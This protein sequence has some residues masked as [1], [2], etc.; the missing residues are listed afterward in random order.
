MTAQCLMNNSRKRAPADEAFCA[1][2]RA[3]DRVS[4]LV[5]LL[6]EAREYVTD[7]LEAMDHSDGRE[8]LARIDAQLG[9]Q[10]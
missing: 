2:H 6:V 7:A 1:E 3:K 10:P 4:T 8:L 5:G 9:E